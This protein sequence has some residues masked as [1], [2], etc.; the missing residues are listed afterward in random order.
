[1][2]VPLN[3]KAIREDL[4]FVEKQLKNLSDPFDTVRLMWQQRKEALEAELSHLEDFRDNFGRVALLFNGAP[5]IGSQEIKLDF[6]AKI[7]EDYQSLVG[8]LVALKAGE[9]IGS[10]GPL[11]ISFS[12]RLYIKD[13]LRG[14]V[15]FL[16]EEKSSLQHELVP[17]LLKDAID[18]T[19][20]LLADMSGDDPAAFQER[21]RQLSPRSVSAIKRIAKTLHDGGAETRIVDDENE[22]SLDYSKTGILHSRLTEV[23]VASRPVRIDG[24]LLGLFP[25]R[26]QYEFR[27]AE[28]QRVIYG[29]VSQKFDSRFLSDPDFARSILLKNALVLFTL[30]VTINSGIIEREEYTLEDVRLLE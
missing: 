7:L 3:A 11:P 21:M 26:Q 14:S 8:T 4:A 17:T 27:I 28:S 29:P 15:G 6:A 1:M 25:E 18:E 24:V 9:S 20:R 23:E 30:S 5:V 19:N 12:S 2:P 13:M 16:I 22:L 10:R